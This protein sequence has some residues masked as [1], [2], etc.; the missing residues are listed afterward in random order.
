[1]DHVKDCSSRSLLGLP[2]ATSRRCLSSR[3]PHYGAVHRYHALLVKPRL[4]QQW[5]CPSMSEHSV[6]KVQGDV[7]A[8]TTVEHEG[9][10]IVYGNVENSAAIQASGDVTVWGRLTGSVHAGYPDRSVAVIR[11]F[12]AGANTCRIGQVTS[13]H[14]AISDV[15]EIRVEENGKNLVVNRQ[16]GFASRP[17]LVDSRAREVSYVVKTAQF[18]GIY[19]VWLGLALMVAPQS[20]YGLLFDINRV[21]HGLIR[22][23]GC[24]LALVGMQYLGTVTA[25]VNEGDG[26]AGFYQSTIFSRLFLVVSIGFFVG[27]GFLEWT[28][29]LFAGLNGIG[30]ISMAVAIQKDALRDASTPSPQS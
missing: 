18:T 26:G 29:L 6:L 14:D 28:W 12:S 8:E 13:P 23:G 11:A 17:Q 24:F 19:A 10:V 27:L 20:I 9:D 3:L 22:L 5:R 25:D 30:A 15:G 2:L 1:M 21:S 16:E 4:H 7:V